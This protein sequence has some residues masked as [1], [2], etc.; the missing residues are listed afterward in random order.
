M[1]TEG[2]SVGERKER[3]EVRKQEDEPEPQPIEEVHDHT[4]IE[5]TD[6]AA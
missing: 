4:A 6:H 2:E 5:E 3:E 1:E